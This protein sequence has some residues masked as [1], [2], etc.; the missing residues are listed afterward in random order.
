MRVEKN[1]KRY[2]LGFLTRINYCAKT[3]TLFIPSSLNKKSDTI[4]YRLLFI[5]SK[6]NYYSVSDSTSS[7]ISVVATTGTSADFLPLLVRLLFL[8][9]SS[10]VL[11]TLVN[12][13]L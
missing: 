9:D 1:G 10:L 4:W 5:F 6:K 11:P 2:F 7:A 13:S 8:P 12:T 3:S